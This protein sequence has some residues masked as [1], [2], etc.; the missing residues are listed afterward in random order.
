MSSAVIVIIVVLV[1]GGIF[2]TLGFFLYKTL[3]NTD[4][5][6]A[7]NV[8]QQTSTTTQ[9]FLPYKDI[10]DSVIDMG[11]FQ[12]RAIIEC[13]SINYELKTE[14]EQAMVELSFQR[15]L[16]SLNYPIQIFIQ[17]RIMDNTKM[18]ESLNADIIKSID[19]FPILEAYGQ[20]Y[21]E[22]MSHIYDEIQNNKEKKKYIVVP[23]NNA[24]ELENATD[25]ERY[26]YA[27]KELQTRCSVIMDSLQSMGIKCKRL[28]SEGILSVMYELF[29]KDSSSQAEALTSGEFTPY[30]VES[31][32]DLYIYDGNDEA[33]LDWILYEAQQRLITELQDK[34][35]TNESVKERTGVVISELNELRKKYAGEFQE[36]VDVDDRI[37]KYE[38]GVN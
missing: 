4:P 35:N 31:E 27:L 29:H 17:T 14:G 32:E 30:I 34:R 26:D 11:G 16:N 33:K 8:K 28:T 38:R 23:F 21:S 19:T 22:C 6:N 12:Y 20:E 37:K 36:N 18:M 7:E 25:A 1:M 5:K 24:V 15:F 3:K 10:K 13:K 9:D 2:G